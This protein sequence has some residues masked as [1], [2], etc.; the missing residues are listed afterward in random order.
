MKEPY[1]IKLTDSEEMILALAA[2]IRSYYQLKKNSHLCGGP[3]DRIKITC[4]HNS[5]PYE[6]DL[7][8][9]EG[10]IRFENFEKYLFDRLKREI[11]FFGIPDN[12]EITNEN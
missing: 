2:D 11:G 7:R 8:S 5:A 3:A 6:F 12:T 4:R 1:T 10:I 9:I